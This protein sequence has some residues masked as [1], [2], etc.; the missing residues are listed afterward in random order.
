MKIYF[1]SESE[2]I[3]TEAELKEFEITLEVGEEITLLAASEKI[4]KDLKLID[5]IF[6]NGY[7]SDFLEAQSFSY[8]LTDSYQVNVFFEVVGDMEQGIETLI[9]ITEIEID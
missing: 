2:R 3:Y 6:D 7:Y 1:D 4:R 8:G 9:K 5:D